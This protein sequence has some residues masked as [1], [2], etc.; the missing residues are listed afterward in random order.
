MSDEPLNQ[1]PTLPE[2]DVNTTPPNPAQGSERAGWSMPDPVF[3]K[4]SGYLP[5]GYEKNF[6]Q[7]EAMNEA[8]ADDAATSEPS[9]IAT[10]A[11]ADVAATP[12]PV[13]PSGIETADVEPQP[14][15]SDTHDVEVKIE[16]DLE[17]PK[18][19]GVMKVVFSLFGILV[20]LGL[21]LIFIAVIYYLFLMP[22]T[23]STF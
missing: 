7:G 15:I 14:D 8:A 1:S 16:R 12:I 13:A 10:I 6:T 18:N 11:E 20:A 21:V 3:R 9:T 23:G 17:T 19:G 5:Q 4:T 2:E 22:S